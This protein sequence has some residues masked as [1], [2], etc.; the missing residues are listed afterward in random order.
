MQNRKPMV[1]VLAG[2]NGSGKTTITDYF[3]TIGEYTNADKI[4]DSTGI[5]NLEAAKLVDERRY[6]SIK[7]KA[8]FTFETVLSSS[9]KMDILRKA[10]EEGYF[11]KCVFVLTS[12]PSIN[13]QRVIARVQSGGHSVD[14]D[15]IV[16]RYH[17]SLNNIK[18][19]MDLCDI[20]HIYDNTQELYRIVRKHKEDISI[21]PNEFWDDKRI[22][23]L[24]GMD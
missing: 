18:E 20:M 5:D 13:V 4:V 12:D 15:K 17:K 19:L 11:I 1:L 3:S 10:K 14:P 24:I 23:K 6:A 22:L 9:Y 2:P 8:D 16:S 21:Y 7:E